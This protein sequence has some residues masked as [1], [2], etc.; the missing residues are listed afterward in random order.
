M[1]TALERDSMDLTVLV[2]SC[3]RLP[4]LE[5]TLAAARAHFAT[6]EPSVKTRWVCFDNG[7]SKDE[8]ARLLEHGFDL[9]LLS[10]ENLGQGPALNQLV[11][12]VRTDYFLLLEDDWV[13]ENPQSIRFFQECR[14]ILEADRRLA[15]VKVDSTYFTDLGDRSIYDGPFRV[16]S[17]VQFFVQNPDMTWGGFCCPPAVTRTDAVRLIGPFAEDQP[18]RRWWAE[19][20]Y[21]AR[22]SRRFC[23]AK[24]PEML[25]FKHIGDEP[26][27]GWATTQTPRSSEA[28]A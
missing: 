8:Q 7:S 22:F 9:L 3:R 5:R 14:C 1:K 19:S 23:V 4:Y 16:G 21:S 2:L 11:G 17:G 6:I 25:L 15:Q 27:S 12:A 18:F 28:C 20:E 13:I 24:S 26:S 10:K